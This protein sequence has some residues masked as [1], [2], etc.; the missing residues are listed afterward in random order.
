MAIRKNE[1]IEDESYGRKEAI[2]QQYVEGQD[3]W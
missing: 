1:R 2:T 3:Y